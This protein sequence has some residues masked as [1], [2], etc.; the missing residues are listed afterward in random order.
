MQSSIGQNFRLFSAILAKVTR[1]SNAIRNLSFTS[2]IVLFQN[3]RFGYF[4]VAFISV[5]KYYRTN[6]QLKHS[7]QLWVQSSM[8]SLIYTA[9]AIT[10]LGGH[11]YQAESPCPC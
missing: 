5:Y 9:A 3:K 6:K 1:P 4:T 7:L 10:G 8:A 11:M 2:H